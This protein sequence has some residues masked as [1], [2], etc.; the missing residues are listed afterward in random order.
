MYF[1]SSAIEYLN[2]TLVKVQAGYIPHGQIPADLNT[3]LVKVQDGAYQHLCRM[4]GI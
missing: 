2:T 1:S 4:A 3:T